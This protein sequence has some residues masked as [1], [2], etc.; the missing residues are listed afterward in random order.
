MIVVLCTDRLERW[1]PFV[2]W[3]FFV[4]IGGG[5]SGTTKCDEDAE[6]IVEKGEPLREEGAKTGPDGVLVSML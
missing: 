6:E 2:L 5:A 3:R 1:I 4:G